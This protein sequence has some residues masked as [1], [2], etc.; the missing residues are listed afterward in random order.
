MKKIK[1]F[2]V[3]RHLFFSIV[4]VVSLSFASQSI[5]ATF[6]VGTSTDLQTALTTAE[7]NSEDDLIHV[8]QGTY[9]GNFVYSSSENFTVTME[10]GYINSCTESVTDPANTVIDGQDNGTVL[11]V[12]SVYGYDADKILFNVNGLTIQ[13]GGGTN[14]EGGGIKLFDSSASIS[15]CIFFN[16]HTQNWGGGIELYASSY[17]NITDSIFLENSSDNRGGGI[18]VTFD[19]D[20]DIAD[21]QFKGNHSYSGGGIA[22]GNDSFSAITNCEFINN[23]SAG[24][25]G[26]IDNDYGFHDISSCTFFGNSAYS[27]GGAISNISASGPIVNCIFADNIADY[28][29]AIWNIPD[30]GP[31]YIPIITNCTIW[32]NTANVYGGGIMNAY[33]LSWPLFDYPITNS[34]IW[35]NTAPTG[36]Q[37]YNEPGVAPEVTYC[38]IEGGYA[39]VGNIDAAPQFID[40]AAY[41]FHLM[42]ESPCIDSGTSVG[43][44]VVD[45]EGESR[46]QGNGIDIGA[47]EACFIQTL[48][49]GN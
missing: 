33:E 29:G 13:N 18:S 24:S 32:R 15:N 10:G 41:D 7:S 30:D 39:G 11:A 19:G 36:S 28:G 45:F 1:S 17:A 25:G 26:A 6:C 38:D 12:D 21:C 46:P 48:V 8:Q 43:A 40:P 5:A 37:I 16:N 4:L 31:W 23:T 9:N 20:A 14:S 3:F 22:L 49:G 42:A 34:I 35:G 27:V 47:D 2:M 44:P